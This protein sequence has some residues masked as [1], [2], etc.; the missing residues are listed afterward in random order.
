MPTDPI[1]TESSLDLFIDESGQFEEKSPGEIGSRDGKDPAGNEPSQVVGFVARQGAASEKEA[2]EVLLNAH[3]AAGLN[4]GREVHGTEIRNAEAYDQLIGKLLQQLEV[5]GWQPVRL[6][7]AT[8]VGRGNPR[9]TY[10]DAVTELAVRTLETLDSSHRTHRSLALCAAIY[11]ADHHGS[12]PDHVFT[13]EYEKRIATGFARSLG[14]RGIKPGRWKL[15]QV[16]TA[17]G[18]KDRRLQ[19]CDLLSNAS[20]RDFRRCSD[21]TRISL[22]TSFGGFDH[23][24]VLCQAGLQARQLLALGAPGVAT[25]VLGDFLTEPDLSN[26]AR[27]EA[28]QLCADSTS[29][30]AD[31]PAGARDSQLGSLIDWV[32]QLTEHLRNP[33]VAIDRIDWLNAEVIAPLKTQLT[34]SD[35]ETLVWFEIE[36]LRWKITANNHLGDLAGA[37]EA[38]VATELLIPQIAGQWEHS[39]SLIETLVVQGVHLTDCFAFEIVESRLAP[40]ADNYG[41]LA[42]MLSDALPGIAPDTIRSELLGKI[43]GTWLQSEIYR[44][45]EA[46]DRIEVARNLSERALAEFSLPTDIKRQ[47]QYRSQLEATAG[48]YDQARR[49]LARSLG[50]DGDSNAEIAANI[51]RIPDERRGFPLLHWTRIGRIAANHGCADESQT[52]AE[53]VVSTELLKSEWSEGKA[54]EYPAHG[55]RRNLGTLLATCGPERTPQAQGFLKKLRA[56]KPETASLAALEMAAIAELGALVLPSNPKAAARILK[57]GSAEHPSL[58]S[59]IKSRSRQFPELKRLWNNIHPEWIDLV[60]DSLQGQEDHRQR[61]LRSAGQVGY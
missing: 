59:L 8:G 43:L 47:Q 4:L 21:T 37:R 18:K 14:M 57:E 54:R 41:Q 29:A 17:S 2:H 26:Q 7:N 12:E 42:S 60:S 38:M 15:G 5:K 58:Q 24:R 33:K 10:L 55:I 22:K 16:G 28:Q 32:K 9:D 3:R 31:L 46:P 27:R 25:R 13:P 61:L 45:W 36:L 34:P 49:W 20:F 56:L 50:A 48:N 53:A 44:S 51:S 6:E 39:E 35:T 1:S 11:N 30:L 19:I 40:I 23:G 52:A